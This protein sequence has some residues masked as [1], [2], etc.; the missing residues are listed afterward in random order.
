MWSLDFYSEPHSFESGVTKLEESKLK[1]SLFVNIFY[2]WSTHGV[3]VKIKNNNN[4]SNPARHL[5]ASREER[6]EPKRYDEVD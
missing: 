4:N 3:D 6:H 1:G 2:P 5:H